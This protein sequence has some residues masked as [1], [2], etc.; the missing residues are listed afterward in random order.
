[1]RRIQLFFPRVWGRARSDDCTV[2]SGIIYVKR[3]GLR[4]Q[5]ALA[6]YDAY[7]TLYDCFA[8][9]SSGSQEA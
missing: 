9:S 7:K 4:W 5:N 8:R 3:C 1:M 2:L 6:V